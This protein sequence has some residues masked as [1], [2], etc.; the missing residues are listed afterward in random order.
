MQCIYNAS[1]KDIVTASMYCD[2]IFQ[3]INQKS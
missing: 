2:A 1:E 3:V